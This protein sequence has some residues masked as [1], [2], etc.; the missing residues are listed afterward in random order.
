MEIKAFFSSTIVQFKQMLH[1]SLV[2]F[3]IFVQPVLYG[4]IMY[5]MFKD[6]GNDNFVGYVILGTGMINLWSSIVYSAAGTIDSERHIGTLE[7]LSAMPVS[8]RTIIGGK[9]TGTVLLGLASTFNGYIFIM[10]ISG[11]KMTIAH[12]ALFLLNLLII[13]LSYIGIAMLLAGLFALSRQVR[14][15]T[16]ASEFPVFILS[17]L[18]F[19]IED[20]P[21]FTRPLS[22]ILSPTWGAKTLRMC[23]FGINDS[24]LYLQDFLILIIITIVYYVGSILLFK[25]L[26][27]KIRYEG[28]L[29]VA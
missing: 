6:S 18:I 8:F 4:L 25:L 17:G 26:M 12:P 24:A 19:P 22:Y 23:V 11:E 3:I 29:G 14:F 7:I 28:S 5:L 21:I 27:K 16:N 15:L 2:Q 9:V 1:S 13:I 20:L 10:L